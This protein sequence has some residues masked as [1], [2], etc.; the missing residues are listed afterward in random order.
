MI[1]SACRYHFVLNPKQPP[2][3][4]DRRFI[5]GIADASDDGKR[6][7]TAAQLHAAIFRRRNRGFWRRIFV[8]RGSDLVSSTVGAARAWR[9]AGRE[10]GPIIDEPSLESAGETQ[11]WTEPDLFDY[12]AEG[13]LVV[14]DPLLVDLLVRNG[15]HT[16]TKVGIIEGRTGYPAGVSR[17]LRPLV[18]E[19][20]DLP[21]FLLHESSI[22]APVLLEDQ[23]RRL[24]GARDNPVIDLGLPINAPGRIPA[25]RWT[26]RMVAVPVDLLP[27][28]WLTT[29]VSTAI[30]NRVALVDLMNPRTERDTGDNLG[31][32]LVWVALGDA[33]LDFDFG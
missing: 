20:T 4:A 21:I 29:G 8:A 7:Y 26:R 28:K 3:C 27:H 13:I 16:T 24:L 30:A 22:P 12:G 25:L 5:A 14:D 9:I 32:D 6:P 10:L 11:R 15:V 18:Q 31:N 17:R 19:R 1:C 33:D 2:Y 23:A